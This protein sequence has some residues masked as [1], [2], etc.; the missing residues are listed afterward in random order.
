MRILALLVVFSVS[1]SGFGQNVDSLY[2]AFKNAK[3]TERRQAGLKIVEWLEERD[4]L[5]EDTDFSKNMTEAE[6]EWNILYHAVHYLHRF[7]YYNLTYEAAQSFQKLAE[8]EN[9]TS[10]LIFTSYYLGFSCQNMGK[11]EE[12]LIHAQRCYELCLAVNHENMLSSVM[13]NIGNIYR[14]NGQD[15]IAV[16]YFLKTIDIERKLGRTQNLATRLGNIATAYINLGKL[17]E[18]LTSVTEGLELEQQI[19]RP[20]KIAIRLHQMCDVFLA[21]KNVEKARECEIEALAYFEKAESK[22]GL[23]IVLNKLGEIE[24]EIQNINLAESYFNQALSYAED[25]QNEL[26]MQGASKNLYML[27]KGTNDTKSLYYFEKSTALRDSLFQIENQQRL[28]EFQVKYETAEKQLEIEQQQTEISRQ[29]TRQQ[30][31]IIVLSATVLLLTLSINIIRNRNRRNRELA[32]TNA[33]KNKY[34]SIISHDLKNPAVNQR[35]ALQLLV[36]NSDRCDRDT[37]TAYLQK[38]YQS[39]EGLVNL[40]DSLLDWAQVQTGRL[41]YNPVQ[42]DLTAAIQSEVAII[43]HIADNKGVKLNIRTPETAI[44]NG[45]YNMLTTVVRNLLTNAVKFTPEGGTVM[46]SITQSNLPLPPPKGDNSSPISPISPTSPISP[47]SPVS[48]KFSVSVSDTG[49]GMSPEQV[50]NLFRLDIK[51]S[52]SGTAGEQGSGLG[53]IVCKELLQKHGSRLHVESEIGKGSR[54]FFELSNPLCF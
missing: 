19:G 53:L 22:Y 23:S 25:I 17:D 11:M 31:F 7:G 13:N 15:S 34:F 8:A 48:P 16:I 21:M 1:V 44:V 46:L 27:Y 32:E 33:T 18:A 12:A 50:Q 51:Q 24:H 52:R 4:F 45:D 10:K 54:F 5:L 39:A 2:V 43:K 35:D 28:N 29:K 41:P 30:F 26:L 47:I 36:K 3:N 42:F 49:I 38:L 6:F 40:L 14:V 9:D 37:L 20:D